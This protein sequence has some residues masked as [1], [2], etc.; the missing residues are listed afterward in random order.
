MKK[1]VIILLIIFSL[2]F[3]VDFSLAEGLNDWDANLDK[4]ALSTGAGYTPGG[5]VESK[6][7]DI[8]SIALSLIGVIFLV[9]MIYGGYLWMTDRGNEE[10]VKKA[11]DL[12][13]S[14]LIGLVIVI[15]AYAISI[16][17]VSKLGGTTLK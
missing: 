16:F 6:M 17:I 15:G 14:A 11:K 3:L 13:V 5:S 8:I 4:A 7:S 2:F 9:L 10:Q 1:A 12:I